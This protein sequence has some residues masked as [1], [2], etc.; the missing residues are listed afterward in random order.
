M[1]NLSNK[2]KL[3]LDN[4]VINL[5]KKLAK[6]EYVE[7][8]LALNE[9][10]YKPCS[11]AVSYPALCVLFSE[12]NYNFPQYNFDVCAHRYLERVNNSLLQNNIYDISLFDGLC[13]VG[14][15]ANCMSDNGKQYQSF[16]RNLNEHILNIADRNMLKYKKM[17]LNET[18]YDI[19]YGLTGIVN[20]LLNFKSESRVKNTLSNIL[21]YLVD[22]CT[23]SI[24]GVPKF[25]IRVNQSQM[26]SL[27]NNSR[28]RYV[29]LGVA[30]GIPGILLIL[31][32]SYELGIYVDNQL[33]AIKYLSEYIFNNCVK[34]NNTIFWESQKI[35]GIENYEA[36]PARDAWCYGTPGV[37]YS[38]LIA[39]KLLD[40]DEMNKLAID[41]MKLSL[42][43]LREVISPTFCHGLSG[44]CCLARKFHEHTND[45]YFYEMYIKLLKNILDLYSDQYPFG[46]INKEVEKGQITN[47]NEIGLLIGTTGVIL[48]I[49]SCYRPIKT[50]WDSIFLL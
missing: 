45:N 35:I 43:R 48:T 26:F 44:L 41:A 13:G 39:S 21:Q 15:A 49:L 1:M 25:A 18:I 30:H 40:N 38:L 17:P 31:C 33:E 50:Q 37:A 4:L 19:M 9:T 27:S 32:K 22:I 29:N 34:N 5:A 3:E 11:V 6:I 20:Y 36:V 47:K 24:D 10:Y 23:T 7:E 8:V 16:I 2:K 46:F 42:N 28:M 12:L 14:F